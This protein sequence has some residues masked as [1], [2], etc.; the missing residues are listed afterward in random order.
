MPHCEASSFVPRLW[1][2]AAVALALGLSACGGL[3][4]AGGGEAVRPGRAVAPEAAALMGQT[5]PTVL[6]TLGQPTLLRKEPVA[7]VWQYATQSCAVFFYLYPPE[8]GAG[9]R[10]VTFIE[11]RP[12]GAANGAIASCL[13]AVV[14]RPVS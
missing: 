14:N 7:E 2:V 1:R 4:L 9:E 10:T 6:A 13:N 8:G 3:G 12:G 5:G 11:A